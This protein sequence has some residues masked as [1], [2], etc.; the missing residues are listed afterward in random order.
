MRQEL[1]GR[2]SAYSGVWGQDNSIVGDCG[3]RSGAR[4]QTTEARSYRELPSF[5]NTDYADDSN[6]NV[7]ACSTDQRRENLRLCLHQR[8]GNTR[9]REERATN[10]RSLRLPLPNERAPYCIWVELAVSQHSLENNRG[11]RSDP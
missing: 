11:S 5:L 1:P 8:R 3:W 4:I 6:D 10:R 9:S 2:L 7:L